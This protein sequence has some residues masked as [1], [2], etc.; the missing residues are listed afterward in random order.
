MTN[1]RSAKAWFEAKG[2]RDIAR[3]FCALTSNVA[4]AR[5]F[6]IG[7]TFGFWDW[8]GGRYSMWSAIGLPIAIAIGPQRF[9]ETAGRRARHGRALPQRT[10]WNEI[11]RCDWPCSTSGI[12]ISTASAAAAWRPITAA[13]VACRPTCSSWRWRAMA[14]V[15]TEDGQALPYAT[16]PVIWG[17]PA[18]NGQHAY[19]QMLHQGS[20]VIPVEFIAVKKVAH[21]AAGTPPQAAGQCAGA[22][23]G[24]DAGAAGCRR[25]SSSAGQPAQHLPAAGR[26]D[27]GQPGRHRSRCTS[28]ASS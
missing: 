18:A 3:H 9:R 2:G 12:A 10:P 26:A 28:T 1:A 23:A 21:A 25:P 8:V 19:F 27:A 15:W 14:S 11:C 20:D 4:A 17:E 16:S 13:C 5:E 7:T 24:A 6:G 22:G